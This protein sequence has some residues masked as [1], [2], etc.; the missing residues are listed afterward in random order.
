METQVQDVVAQRA[1]I[2]AQIAA[3]KAEQNSQREALKVAREEAKARID[4]D[5]CGQVRIAREVCV[6]SHFAPDRWDEEAVWHVSDKLDAPIEVE[7]DYEPEGLQL[8]DDEW[9]V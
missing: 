7:P 9:I 1:A 3:M 2:Q 8:C 5:V 6:R 4:D